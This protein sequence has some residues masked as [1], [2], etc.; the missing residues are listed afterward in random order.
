MSSLYTIIA[1]YLGGTYISQCAANDEHE[2]L[3]NWVVSFANRP[4]TAKWAK[5]LFED[6]DVDGLGRDLVAIDGV[7]H[8]W[9]TTI[10]GANGGAEI[11]IVRTAP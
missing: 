1:Q 3:D 5:I 8:V 11:N 7:I 9:Y 6:S 10:D 4:A 2:A